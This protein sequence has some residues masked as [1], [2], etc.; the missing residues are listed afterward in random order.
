MKRRAAALLLALVALL[1]AA[2][3]GVVLLLGDLY[4]RANG[5][6]PWQEQSSLAGGTLCDG[7]RARYDLD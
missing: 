3:S 6:F 2:T 1:V 4:L 7:E 5:C